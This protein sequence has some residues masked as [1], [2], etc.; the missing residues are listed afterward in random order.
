MLLSVCLSN[1]RK[2]ETIKNLKEICLFNNSQF[3]QLEI[4]LFK[5]TFAFKYEIEEDKIWN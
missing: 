2:L 3:I 4:P 5:S 1:K